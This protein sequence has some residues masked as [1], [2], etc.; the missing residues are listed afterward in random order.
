MLRIAGHE[1]AAANDMSA[2]SMQTQATI[3]NGLAAPLM[4]PATCSNA[5]RYSGLISVIRMVFTATTTAATA[6][7]APPNAIKTVVAMSAAALL[8]AGRR[9][10]AMPQVLPN[11]SQLTVL[12]CP[13]GITPLRF[14]GRRR[15]SLHRGWGVTHTLQHAPCRWVPSTL[16]AAFHALPRPSRGSRAPR[17]PPSRRVVRR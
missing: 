5:I 4:P 17:L 8:S 7:S 11:K 16:D 14:Y 9:P 15:R 1:S 2:P 3:T 6:T 10:N 13:S 12:H